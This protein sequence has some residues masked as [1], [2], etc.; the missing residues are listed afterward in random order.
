MP[1]WIGIMNFLS[2]RLRRFAAVLLVLAG[3]QAVHA[4]IA[5]GGTQASIPL[6]R[7]VIVDAGLRSSLD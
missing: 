7:A 1:H 6:E 3:A 4:G 2:A 5:A